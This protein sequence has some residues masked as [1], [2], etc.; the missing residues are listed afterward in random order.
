MG[1]H[2]SRTLHTATASLL[3]QGSTAFVDTT[4]GWT[5]PDSA[6]CAVCEVATPWPAATLFSHHVFALGVQETYLSELETSWRN[7]ALKYLL[8]D[9]GVFHSRTSPDE[10]L[11]FYTQVSTFQLLLP[12]IACVPLL[13]LFAHAAAQYLQPL[14]GLT[15]PPPL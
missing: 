12:A 5:L 13:L 2:K 10:A 6:V 14:L 3:S 4:Q 7:N 15:Y 11:D 1:R 8:Q 9:A